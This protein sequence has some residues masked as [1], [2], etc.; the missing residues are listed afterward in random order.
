M[1]GLDVARHFL[2]KTSPQ[3]RVVLADIN[4]KGYEAVK[5][6]LDAD[7]TLFVETDVTDWDSHAALFVKA[8]EFSNKQ[9]DFFHANAGIA[10][11]EFILQ[12]FDLD[13]PPQKPNLQCLDVNL[14]SVFYGLK[15]FI[16]YAR[17]TRT[18]QGSANGHSSTTFHPKMV[19]T[20]S[21]AGQYP[22]ELA[23]QYAATK[24]A[25][26]NLTRSAAPAMYKHDDIALNCLMPAFLATNILPKELVQA[27]PQ[28][29]ITP[30]S[31]VCRAIDECISEKGEIVQDS[32]SDGKNGEVKVAQ[33]LEVAVDKLYYRTHVPFADESQRFIIEE[34]TE[35]GLWGR[36]FGEVMA[37]AAAD[38][39]ANDGTGFPALDGSAAA[40]QH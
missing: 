8:Y 36:V 35:D 7:R 34:A 3:W 37:K 23:P 2:A 16:H 27:W 40:Q 12:P 19:I 11:K 21:C 9:I 5:G 4:A 28:K 1:K 14:I 39:A 32:K 38:G 25:C 26:I 20:A 10:D 13:Q 6:S 31:T 29:W 30:T 17:K 22:F 24:A 33:S 18:A 15:L